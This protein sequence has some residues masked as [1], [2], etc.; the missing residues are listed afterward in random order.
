MKKALI[1]ILIFFIGAFKIQAQVKFDTCQY[2]VKFAGEWRY[3]NG[4]DTI[5][6]YLRPIRAFDTDFQGVQDVLYGW[7]EYKKGNIIIESVYQNRFMPVNVD[8]ITIRSFSIGLKMGSG[9]DCNSSSRTASGAIN[10]YLQANETKVVTITL[11][12]TGTIMTWKQRHSEGYGVFTGAT[13]MTLPREFVLFK[14]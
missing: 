7:H 8:T 13:G 11:D 4:I 3:A 6:V 14:Q 5:R 12:P 2:I 10:D 1:F 9:L